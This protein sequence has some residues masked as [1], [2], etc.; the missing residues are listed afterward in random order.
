MP[1][2]WHSRWKFDG[3]ILKKKKR[4]LIYSSGIFLLTNTTKAFMSLKHI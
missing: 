4:L 2:L 1:C 3:G